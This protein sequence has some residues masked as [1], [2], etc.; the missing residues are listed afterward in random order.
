VT[1]SRS[2]ASWGFVGFVGVVVLLGVDLSGN[3]KALLGAGLVLAAAIGFSI[4]PL[5]FK[6]HLAHLNP[7]ATVGAGLALATLVLTPLAVLNLPTV[8]PSA[9]TARAPGG[10]RVLLHLPRHWS[11]SPSSLPRSVSAGRC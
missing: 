3:D 7:N 9:S 2:S 10:A 6:R 5:V 8:M 4:G 11:S 1:R